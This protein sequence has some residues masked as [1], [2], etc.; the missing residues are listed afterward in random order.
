M[1]LLTV[2]LFVKAGKTSRHH[3]KLVIWEMVTRPTW[4]FK[5]SLSFVGLV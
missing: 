1:L 3:Q 4:V 2:S 5:I